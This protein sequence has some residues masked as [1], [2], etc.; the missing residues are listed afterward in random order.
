LTFFVNSHV[1]LEVTTFPAVDKHHSEITDVAG[2]DKY[3]LANIVIFEYFSSLN[4][5][6][7]NGF[8]SNFN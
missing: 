1:L 4:F 2:I 6:Q 5:H 7:S 8:K 3:F